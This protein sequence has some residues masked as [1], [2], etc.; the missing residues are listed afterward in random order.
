[1]TR[2]AVCALDDIEKGKSQAF[3]ENGLSILVCRSE[4]EIYAIENRCT[5]QETPLSEGRIRRGF[6]SC[7]VHGVRFNLKTGEPHGTLTRIPVKTFATTIEDG[8]VH[9]DVAS[10]SSSEHE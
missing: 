6:I 2:I 9:V 3:D 5:H 7:P 1:M 8:L 10:S 4:G